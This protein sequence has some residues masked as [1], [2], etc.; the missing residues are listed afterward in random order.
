MQKGKIV[1]YLIA[2]TS[3]LSL[4][5]LGSGAILAYQDTRTESV[6]PQKIAG[7][8]QKPTG[9]SPAAGGSESVKSAS[10][11][12]FS[13]AQ[14]EGDYRLVALGDSLTRGTGDETGQG[15]VGNLT[16]ELQK[17]TKHQVVAT[18]LGIN[19]MKAP[20]LL[21]YIQ[22]PEVQQ[23]IKTAHLITLSIGGNDL[24][25]GAGAISDPNPELS[26]QTQDTYL[27]TL[28]Q[29]F[30]EIRKQNQTAPVLF[31]GLYNPFALDGDSLQTA[32][33]ILEEWNFQT[34]RLLA[35][36]QPALLVPTQDLFAWNGEKRLSVDRFHPNAEGYKEIALRMA[37]SL[38]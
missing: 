12:T 24:V 35:K 25:R 20:E 33:K 4:L 27:S 8:K 15:F 1:W 17:L 26:K 5:L 29:I 21:P 18:N 30:T 11:P 14:V 31:V 34:S 3:A 38:R 36:H 16:A 22:S 32:Y 9:D 10:I 7:E 6:Q 2:A 37:Q 13:P 19:G 28:D 23:E